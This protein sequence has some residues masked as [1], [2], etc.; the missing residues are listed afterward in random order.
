MILKVKRNSDGSAQRFK[1]RL[2]ARGFAQRQG[3][4]YEEVFAPTVDFSSVR[5]LLTIA[6]REDLEVQ[7]A[8][9]KTAYLNASL[10]E[11]IFM[12]QP[13]GLE[14]PGKADHVCL[15]QKSLYGLKQ[16]GR[17][18]H[19]KLSHDLGVEG[20][21]KLR[22]ESC[23][24]RK[25]QCLVAIYVDDMLIV[26]SHEDVETT[27]E[28][29]SKLYDIKHLGAARDFLGIR[30]ERDR[31]RREIYLSQ[32]DYIEKLT[33]TYGLK[34][35]RPL[36]TPASIEPSMKENS[37]EMTTKPFQELTGSLLYLSTRTRPDISFAVGMIARKMSNYRLGDFEKARRILRYLAGPR[38]KVM[39]LG[40][41][42][43]T[44]TN[45]G[46]SSGDVEKGQIR[47]QVT[48][49]SD[50]SWASHEDSRSTSGSVIM[51]EGSPVAYRSWKQ[52][53][54]AQSTAEAEYQALGDMLTTHRWVQEFIVETV[55][56]VSVPSVAY[57]DNMSCLR[58]ATTEDSRM[59]RHV[60]VKLQYAR[61]RCTSEEVAL[62]YLGT[63]KMIADL[64]TKP[65]TKERTNILRSGL[66][67]V[68]RTSSAV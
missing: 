46:G 51:I 24:F 12:L 61:E 68:D 13:R 58:W 28:A 10:R 36:S 25:D 67:V 3:I 17:E 15:L 57:T 32:E 62:T 53:S 63:D 40:G 9:V 66:G 27:K 39:K 16:A 19:N 44:D 11:E 33:Y 60:S 18:C 45:G 14:E 65:L 4:D 38:E 31:E 43:K 29:L 34:G 20:F 2:V 35:C 41:V 5:I 1:A 55:R 23:I 47:Y 42:S 7:Q 59:S 6:A 56:A 50:A 52:R 54:V 37:M 64:L 8:D 30:I 26:G 49:Y 48:G 22:T 21:E